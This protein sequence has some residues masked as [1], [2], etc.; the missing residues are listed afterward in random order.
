MRWWRRYLLQR[1]TVVAAERETAASS[2]AANLS[3]H[4]NVR[5]P[6]PSQHDV[7]SYFGDNFAEDPFEPMPREKASTARPPQQMQSSA[8]TSVAFA[9]RHVYVKGWAGYGR[10]GTMISKEDAF[11]LAQQLRS[12]LP[13]EIQQLLATAMPPRGENFQVAF[14]MKAA[15]EDSCTAV[16]LALKDLIMKNKLI[17]N[18]RDLQVVI[19]PDPESKEFRGRVGRILAA[20]QAAVRT[21]GMQ[22]SLS[23]DWRRPVGIK[24][25]DDCIARVNKGGRE[26]TPFLEKLKKLQI[27]IDWGAVN[28]EVGDSD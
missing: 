12:Q 14:V 10:K 22:N 25:G 17:V 28:E 27:E 19:E 9:P 4:A 6:W 18:N 21:D 5:M 26:I 13:P 1:K 16:Q 24:C 11:S 8:L 2:S 20:C 3:G 23:I 7:R 15:S